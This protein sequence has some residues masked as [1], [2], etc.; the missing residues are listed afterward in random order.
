MRH[1]ILLCLLFACGDSTARGPSGGEFADPPVDFGD[2]GPATVSYRR[3]IAPIFQAKCIACHYTGSNLP[4]DLLSVF[5]PEHGPINFVNTWTGARNKIILVPGKPEESALIDKVSATDLDPH[6]EGGPMPNTTPDV[7]EAEIADVAK[8]IEDGAKD[9]ETYR[10]KIVPLFGNGN[11]NNGGGKCSTC[12]R[13][14]SLYKPDLVHPF[15]E[16]TGIV[17]V[18]AQVGGKRVVPGDPD[19]SVLLRKLRDKDLPKELGAHMPRNFDAVTEDE[20]AR[21]TTW[22]REGARNN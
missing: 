8:W 1:S 17:N 18:D 2:A 9:D 12:H 21:L 3:D 4:P 13:E 22:I 20:V 7:T 15:N 11:P 6:V 10:T 19:A 14:G 5:D 16:T